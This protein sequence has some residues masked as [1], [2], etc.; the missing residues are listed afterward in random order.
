LKA[1]P[2]N[3]AHDCVFNPLY[4]NVY[5]KQPNTIQPFGLRV[6]T[7]QSVL[8]TNFKILRTLRLLFFSILIWGRK[9]SLLSK[10]RPKNLVSETILIGALKL[11]FERLCQK[12][13]CCVYLFRF[14][15]SIRHNME[16]WHFK[17]PL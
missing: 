15:K 10:R 14:R 12:G 2:S 3:P 11:L 8:D 1:Y 6:N 13:T 9:V 4:E 7:P 16:I 5:D 17:R